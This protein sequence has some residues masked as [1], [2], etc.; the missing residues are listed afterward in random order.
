VSL[1]PRSALFLP[2][3]QLSLIVVDEEH[4]ALSSRRRAFTHQARDLA[5]ARPR[6]RRPVVWLQRRLRRWNPLRNAETGSLL[7]G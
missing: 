7:A 5:V 4:D 2:Y 1:A 3:R 6:S